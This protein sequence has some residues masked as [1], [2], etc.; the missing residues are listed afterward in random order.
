M[1]VFTI[2]M[3]VLH[4]LLRFQFVHA[5]FLWQYNSQCERSA[6]NRPIEESAIIKAY[7]ILQ[8]CFCSHRA[9]IQ[10]L[11]TN[12]CLRIDTLFMSSEC[13]SKENSISPSFCCT[14]SVR[15]Y[16]YHHLKNRKTFKRMSTKKVT[17]NTFKCTD[18]KRIGRKTDSE[19]LA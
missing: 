12:L 17:R 8:F 7:I 16:K 3:R 18:E 9:S 10:M 1:N 6:F 4:L 14:I 2:L 19:L 13:V 15:I 5:I 11:S